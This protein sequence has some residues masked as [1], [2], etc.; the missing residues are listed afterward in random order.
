MRCGISGIKVSSIGDAVHTI[1]SS[2]TSVELSGLTKLE[3]AFALL[4]V[5]A[6]AGLTLMLGLADRRRTFAI[7]MAIGAR[8]GQLGV[9]IWPEALIVLLAGAAIGIAF[10]IVIAFILVSC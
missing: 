5:G 10:G 2:L 9:F 7:L 8:P 6:A 3:L 1:G 4:M